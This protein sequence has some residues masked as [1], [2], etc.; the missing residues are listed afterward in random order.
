MSQD[1]DCVVRAIV[2]PA[3]GIA[4]VGNSPEP[5]GFYLAP[6]VPRVIPSLPDVYRDANQAI[7][8]QAQRFRVYGLDADGC[9][10]CELNADN[11][12]VTWTVHVANR[13][14]HWYKFEQAL[15]IPAS[16]V[17]G[18]DGKPLTLGLRN[19]SLE[20]NERDALAIDGGQVVISG[21]TANSQGADTTK[22]FNGQFFSQDVYLGELRTDAAGR[23]IFLGGRGLSSSPEGRKLESFGN[24]PGWHDDTSDGPVDAVVRIGNRTLQAEGAWVLT[25]PPNYAPGI[26]AFTTGWDLLLE[27][28]TELDPSLKVDVPTFSDHVFPTLERLSQGQWVNAGFAREFGWGSRYD[29]SDEA[30]VQQLNDTSDAARHLR[31]AVWRQ[32]RDAFYTEMQTQAWP[33]VYGEALVLSDTA[34]DAR[35]W[36]AISESQYL[37][38]RKWAEGD[39]IPDGPPGPPKPWDELDAKEQAIALDRAALEE[40]V[41]GPFHPGTEYTWPMRHKSMYSAPF[42]LAR[43]TT[44]EPDY[45]P[46]LDWK[47][48]MAPNG[49]LTGSFPGSITRWMACP[50]QTD[51]ASCLSAYQEYSGDY[52]PTF[53]PSRVPNDVLT[54]EQYA[55]VDD[56]SRPYDQR[57]EAFV[58]SSRQKWLR[59]IVYH[60]SEKAPPP[61]YPGIQ[62][63]TVFTHKW[64]EVGTV[65]KHDGPT[66]GAFPRKLWVEIGR[67]FGTPPAPAP[68]PEGDRRF[69]KLAM[70]RV[71]RR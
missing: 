19:E 46:G 24:N 41:G 42:R 5:D 9:Y 18:A 32:F 56:V 55:V 40:T 44:P 67:T 68:D 30:F 35:E 25:A 63:M 4:R 69:A 11:A 45:G 61:E 66:D 10:V 36:W 23:L 71:R 59:G 60:E 15:D 13:K 1:L 34:T 38:L 70:E 47:Q 53:W 48:A 33:A 16:Q 12:D 57:E 7:K 43:R 65:L 31:Q 51:T 27:V 50:W 28:G 64:H 58:F 54:S 14:A 49:P 3:I 22:Q 29:F 6:E 39:F 52:L 8:R 20:G 2:H 26:T 62:R 21:A 17:P 37:W